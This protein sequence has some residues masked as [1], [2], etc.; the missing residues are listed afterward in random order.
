MEEHLRA[1]CQNRGNDVDNLGQVGNF[2]D[3]RVTDE[4]VEEPGKDQGVFQIVVLFKQVG[5][6]LALAVRFLVFVL[7]VPLIKAQI[8]PFGTALSGLY[9]AADGIHL[10]NLTINGLGDRAQEESHDAP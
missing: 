2:E 8:G 9:E 7:D 1:A 10:F 4:A 5:S 3:I 6:K